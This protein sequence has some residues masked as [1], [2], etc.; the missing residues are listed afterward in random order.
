MLLSD[1]PIRRKL[2]TAF[3]LTSGS[4]LALTCVAFI[5]YEIITL[6]K[7]LVDGYRTRAEIIA[8]NS[9][10]SLAFQNEADAT[11]VLE[12]LETD[13]R[14]VVACIYDGQGKIF[15]K[16]PA[17]TSSAL[18]PSQPGDS[19]Y[20]GGHLDIFCPVIQ[21]D[22]T[23]GTVYLKTNLSALT[24]RYQAYMWLSAAI[25]VASLLLAYLLSRALQK[26][27]SV[28]ILALTETAR[29]ISN[30]QD[31]SVRAKKFGADELGYLTDAF[32]QML[33]EILAREQAVK[34]SEANYREIFD[35][36][37]DGIII[38]DPEA[39]ENPILDMNASLEKMTGFSLEEYKKVPMKK[40][41]STEPGFTAADYALLAQKALME[42]PQLFEWLALH[43]DGHTYWI[44]V[45]LQKT[46]LAGKTRL[47]AFM[48][49]ISDRKRLAEITRLGEAQAIESIK[50]YA[51][52]LLDREGK[53]LTWNAGAETIKGYKRAEILGKS[54]SA[55]YTPEDNA[56]GHPQELLKAAA[57]KGRFEEEGWRVRKDGSRFEADVLVTALKN[58]KDELRGFVKVTRDVT[59]FK[60]AQRELQEKTELLD[61]IL[62]NIAD[63]VVV[64]DE[65]GQFLLFNP[66][67]EKITGRSGDGARE[68]QWTEQFGIFLPDQKTPFPEAENPLA[69]AIQGEET[70]NVEM[71]LRN[72]GHPEGILVSAS[73]R[74]LKDEKGRKRGGVAI[75][76]NVTEQKKAEEQIK[77]ANAFL[78]TVLENLPNMVFVKDAKDLKFVM[79]NKAGEDLLGILRADLIGKN[80]YDF[81]PKAE[82]DFFTSKDQKT[83]QD[84]RL[85]DIPEETIQTRHHGPRMLHTKKI[86]VMDASGIPRFLLGISEDITEQK[87]QENLRI[88]AKALEASNKD[89]Q[90]FIFVASHDLQEPLRKIQAFGNFLNEEEGKSLTETG[91]DYLKRIRDASLRMS[92]LLS[93]LL[94]LTRITTRAKPFTPVVLNEIVQ[95]VLSDLEIRLEETGGKVEAEALPTLD[96][97]PAQMRQLFQNLIGNALKFHKPGETPLIRISATID[98][99]EGV[100]RIQVKDNGIGFDS[101]YAEKIFNIF[102]R[103]HGQ[104][105]YPGTGIGLAICR[106]VVERHGG[107]IG[108]QSQEGAGA[109]FVITLPLRQ[110]VVNS[111]QSES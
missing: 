77:Q 29:A 65:K 54:I 87:K 101:K 34:A 26:Q 19:G 51:I 20:R 98:K 83:I 36:A 4:V 67:A 47:I 32:N 69:K 59:E 72:P 82:A 66:A 97:D 95:E 5:T 85:L 102:Q 11:E 109:L 43:K 107:K 49:D 14:I 78:N 18:F 80:D 25:I 50:D 94:D 71:F 76:R 81:F 88:Y 99:G 108:A 13:K 39:I 17:D 52:I 105:Q 89:L 70:N 7:G 21:G 27:I 40:L 35:K 61:S 106:K 33:A 111:K 58:E 38:T 53:V 8:A 42:G 10:A 46:I 103:L 1:V 41:F 93:D 91:R 12:A 31:F 44:E 92:T 86:P 96:A 23:L 74:P 84:G 28:P 79:F 2:M 22:R 15:A 64:G 16:Y 37:N 57:E 68:G 6:H 62:K 110:S 45:S 9:T 73:S 104:G 63:G 24:D 75:F 55:F 56:K 90:D 100:C 3:L 30:H 60:K 48:R